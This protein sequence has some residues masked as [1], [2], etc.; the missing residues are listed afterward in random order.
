MSI[1]KKALALLLVVALTAAIAVNVTLAYLVDEKSDVNVM[2]LGN[3]KIEQIEQE[4][5]A[6]GN[7]KTFSQLKPAYPAVGPVEWATEGVEVNGVKY[8]VF[9]PDLKNVVDK[10]ITV[11]NVGKSDAFVR[12]VVAIEA[13]GHD[14]EDY[15]H[16]NYNGTD[17]T[18]SKPIESKIDGIDYV[19]IVYTYKTALAVGEKSAPSLVQVFLDSMADNEYCAKFGDTWEIFAVSQAV[20]TEGF[21]DAETALNTAFG[22][23]DDKNHPWAKTSI[24]T[25]NDGNELLEALENGND[26]YLNTD[27]VTIEETDFDGKGAEI[28]LIAAGGVKG[29]G[30]SDY[31]Y[32]SFNPGAGNTASVNNLNVTG[33]GF[34]EFGHHGTSTGGIYTANNL[35]VSDLVATLCI[36]EGGNPVAAAFCHYGTATL[37][38][39]VMTGTTSA[40]PAYKPYDASFVNGT[41]TTIDGSEFG[42]IY[43][44]AQAHVTI[45]NTEIDV[46][47]SCAISTRNLGKLTIG[48]GTHVGTINLTPAG[49][50][51]P[52][53]V[54]KTGATVGSIVYNGTTYTQAEW[55]AAHP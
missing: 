26:V 9:T 34:V 13:P 47:D 35:N 12:T 27:I 55:V 48:E 28:T 21:S 5:D 18:S 19:I 23:I 2:T 25:T 37:K 33:S 1:F 30:E 20:Q 52:A 17:V 46:I 7:L 44:A 22:V 10:I 41:K 31:G 42:K 36:T 16:I 24:I 49:T 38:N 51:P 29:S 11:N 8:K 40:N 54:I 6:N 39:C 53:L 32:L 4:R 3:V 15:I 43:L 14:K 50:Y 45:T